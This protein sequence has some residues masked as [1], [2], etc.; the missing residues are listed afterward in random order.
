MFHFIIGAFLL[1]F[2]LGK[3]SLKKQTQQIEDQ[4]GNFTVK[5]TKD[6]KKP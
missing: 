3:L 1:G 2:F 6:G 5:K 4:S